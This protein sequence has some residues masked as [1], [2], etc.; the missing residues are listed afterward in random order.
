MTQF[1]IVRPQTLTRVGVADTFDGALDFAGREVIERELPG[2]IVIFE[3]QTVA[4]VDEHGDAHE[5]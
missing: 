2:L 5:V 3:G 4:L 1:E